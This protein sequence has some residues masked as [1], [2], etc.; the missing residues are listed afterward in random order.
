LPSLHEAV[1]GADV[2]PAVGLQLS[3]VHAFPSSG[4]VRSA[5]PTQAPPLH[6]S[7]VVQALPSSQD[8][9][10]GADV[11]PVAGLQV[12]TVHALPSSGQVRACPPHVPPLHV[13]F[14]VQ[15]LPSL[16]APVF[17]VD[18]HPVVGL[19]LSVV[20]TLPSSAQT[21]GAPP[22]QA[23]AAPVQTPGW[24]HALPSSQVEPAG[25]N[26]SDG[27][28]VPLPLQV[29]WM[30]HA[31]AEGRHTNPDGRNWSSGHTAV[32]PSH[33]SDTSQAAVGSA[34]RQ[35]KPAGRT[36][37]AG[38]VLSVALQTSATSQVKP[39]A[40]GRQTSPVRF[41]SPGHRSPMPSQW[42][43]RSHSPAAS[44]Q[45]KVGGCLA[46]GQAAL[47]PSQ[48]SATSQ[49][50]AE[51]RHTVPAG[52]TALARGHTRL[53]PQVSGKSQV[54][55]VAAPRQTVLAGAGVV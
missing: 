22:V 48:V 42:S 7:L 9:A 20:H 13:S 23:A 26:E 50:P 6:V 5:P 36:W 35:A 27:Q 28:S 18:E 16:Q 52:C 14:V 4:H 43:S 3:V 44:R 24:V 46:S 25:W 32:L 34:G 19:Q 8:P 39:P 53:P 51:G 47:T 2:H 29:S 12:S 40:A 41:A 10:T 31:P 11:H 54:P 37:L 38:H 33:V 49:T 21:T 17:G 15:A 30:S 55:G 1:F 45:V